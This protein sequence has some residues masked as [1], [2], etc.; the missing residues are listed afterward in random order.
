VTETAYHLVGAGGIGMSAIARLLLARGALV[1]GSDIART[2]LIEALEEAGMRSSI[3]HRAA[4]I[5][6]AEVVVV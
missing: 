1:S 5:G 4:N 6:D 3:G 2:P